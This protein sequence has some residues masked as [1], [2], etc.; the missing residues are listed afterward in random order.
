MR[1]SQ[2][3]V[4]LLQRQGP[5]RAAAWYKKHLGIDVQDWGGTAFTWA[6][7]REIRRR[8]RPSGP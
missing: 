6:D 3:S 5:R 7:A 1:E 4:D 2:A 8:E